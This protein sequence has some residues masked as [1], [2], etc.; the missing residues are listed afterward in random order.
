MHALSLKLLEYLAIGLNKDRYFFYPWFEQDSL[1]TYRAIHILP[2]STNIRD[3]SKMSAEHYKLTT[4]EHCDSGF[5]TI[6]ST[7]GY[8]GLQVLID[9]QFRSVRPVYN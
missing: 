1:S 4:P 3:Y 9:G 7:L 6:L 8:P 2:R 5:M